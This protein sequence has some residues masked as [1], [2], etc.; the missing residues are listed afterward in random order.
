MCVS[1]CLQLSPIKHRFSILSYIALISDWISNRS[2]S[3]IAASF[4]LY[5]SLISLCK[6]CLMAATDWLI[7]VKESKELDSAYCQ[8]IL[9]SL[10]NLKAV[11]GF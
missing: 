9:G 2:T 3:V 11:C 1:L 7:S 6:L 5:S 10:T 4:F 8:T